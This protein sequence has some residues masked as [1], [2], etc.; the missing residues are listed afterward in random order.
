M[1]LTWGLYFPLILAA[2]AY[3]IL[4]ATGGMLAGR[5]NEAGA[6][7]L[8][9][10]AFLIVLLGGVWVVVLLLMALISQPDDL[11][12]MVIITLVIVGFF[13]ILL[14][15]LFGLSLLVGR[16]SRSARRRSRVTTDEL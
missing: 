15:V 6:E 13:A 9:S 4:S 8:R 2:A 14:M 11:W 7:R 10:L 3:A 16:V 5:G 1:D 12:D